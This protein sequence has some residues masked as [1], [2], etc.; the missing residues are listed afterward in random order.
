M[1]C[2]GIAE[3]EIC[4]MC[5][6][7]SNIVANML[8]VVMIVA[9]VPFMIASPATAQAAG[10]RSRHLLCMIVRSAQKAHVDPHILAAIAWKESRRDVRGGLGVP[11]PYTVNMPGA[12][13]YLTSRRETDEV[14]MSALMKGVRPHRID[15]G[16]MQVNLGYGRRYVNHLLELTDPATNI[17]VAARMLAD[18][19][20][21]APASVPLAVRVGRYHSRRT[22]LANRYGHAVLRLADHIIIPKGVCDGIGNQK[23]PKPGSRRADRMP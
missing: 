14:I 15:V 19:M 10:E 18:A 5:N 1:A 6:S 4:L 7:V 21:S 22:K 9:I 3:I 23:I 12:S 16:P 2:K 8:R 11:W 20:R 17:E 13:Y